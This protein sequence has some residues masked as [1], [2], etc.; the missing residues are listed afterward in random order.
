MLPRR[1][2]KKKLARHNACAAVGPMRKKTG[3]RQRGTKNKRSLGILARLESWGA[4]PIKVLADA[5]DGKLAGATAY[6]RIAAAKE[7]RRVVAPDARERPLQIDLPAIAGLDDLPAAYV[8]MF[9]ALRMGDLLPSEAQVTTAILSEV[10]QGFIA[11][12][13]ESRLAALEAQKEE[14]A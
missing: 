11:T 8:A 12:G 13:F 1:S 9:D 2:N 3:G 6:D 14:M 7:L 5:M 4:D 10:R